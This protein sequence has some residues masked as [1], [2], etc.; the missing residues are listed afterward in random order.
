M[1]NVLSEEDNKETN[2]CIKTVTIMI[3]AFNQHF[4]DIPTF[5]KE[6]RTRAIDQYELKPY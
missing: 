4:P 6:P 5:K 2:G 3:Q 1:R